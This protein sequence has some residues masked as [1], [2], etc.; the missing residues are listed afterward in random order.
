RYVRRLP[1][2]T[3]LGFQVGL[4]G[5]GGGPDLKDG[6]YEAE[7]VT[8]DGTK[9]RVNVAR[10][11]SENRGTFSTQT[12]GVYRIHVKGEGKDPSGNVVAGEASARVIVYDEDTELTRPAADP[13]FLKKLTAASGG[14]AL[15]VEQLP[16]FLNRL[17]ER[18]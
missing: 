15:R 14:E 7:V 11:V 4:R 16:D 5:K 12:P 18:P 6:K 2:R 13:E 17:A 8:P 10:S 1:V 9:S 3:D